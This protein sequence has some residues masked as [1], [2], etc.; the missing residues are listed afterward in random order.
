M[1]PDYTVDNPIT[2]LPNP[3]YIKHTKEAR[4]EPERQYTA[5]IKDTCK[6]I[7][8]RYSVSDTTL[9]YLNLELTNCITPSSGTRLCLQDQCETIYKVHSKDDICIK[10][11]VRHRT[12]WTKLVGWNQGL[13]SPCTTL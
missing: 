10:A 3:I 2:V 4:C 5:Q 8:E 12:S 1:F 6:S 9:Y 11:A 7:A 13:D